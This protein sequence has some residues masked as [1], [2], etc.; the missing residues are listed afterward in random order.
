[1]GVGIPVGGGVDRGGTRGAE[2]ERS[3]L[4]ELHLEL[5]LQDRRWA[6]RGGGGEGRRDRV[7]SGSCPSGIL[8]Q[9]G[10]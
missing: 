10:D 2:G 7:S 6:G 5:N 8:S 3:E 4:S 1:M 9:G